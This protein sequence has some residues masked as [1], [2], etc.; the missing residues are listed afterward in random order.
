MKLGSKHHVPC[1][2]VF[3]GLISARKRVKAEGEG[4]SSCNSLSSGVRHSHYLI[5]DPGEM[6]QVVTGCPRIVVTDTPAQ[7][8][9]PRTDQHSASLFMAFINTSALA[10]KIQ[11]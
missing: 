10:K 3:L 6:R 5:A 9:P 4:G 1:L 2:V 11:G 7:A 8:A